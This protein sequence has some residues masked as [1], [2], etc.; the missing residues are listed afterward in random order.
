MP[1]R[2]YAN[3]IATTFTRLDRHRERSAEHCSANPASL[4]PAGFRLAPKASRLPLFPHVKELTP[5]AS[6]GGVKITPAAKPGPG[7]K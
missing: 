3:A 7:R 2:Y 5:A 4:W 1:V 6:P